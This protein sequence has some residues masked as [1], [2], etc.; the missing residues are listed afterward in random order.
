MIWRLNL[1]IL[2]FSSLFIRFRGFFTLKWQAI[3]LCR[4]F[5][6]DF[7]K[8]VMA[9]MATLRTMKRTR[10][11]RRLKQLEKLEL[12]QKEE[13]QRRNREKQREFCREVESHRYFRCSKYI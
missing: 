7:F 3:A 8:P 1:H 9:D 10:A 12:K 5:L 11:G 6:H 13:R 2:F 4:D